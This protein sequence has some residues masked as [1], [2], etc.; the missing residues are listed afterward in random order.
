MNFMILLS[1]EVL[2]V[3][4]FKI[5]CLSSLTAFI[6]LYL[7]FLF[8]LPYCIDLNQYS[9]QITRSIQDKT[10]YQIVLRDLK[11]KT[12]WNLSIGAL[13]DKVDLKYSN[14]EKFAQINNL[15]AKFSLLPFLFKKVHIDKIS[16]DKFLANIEDAKIPRCINTKK[17]YVPIHNINIKKYRI[18]YL[19]N[20]ND[21]TIK[22]SDLEISNFVP[23]K[24]IKINTK[25]G[26]ILNKRKQIVYDLA[27]NSEI[28]PKNEDN[29]FDFV[30]IFDDLYNYDVNAEIKTDLHIRKDSID[31]KVDIDKLSFV[32]GNHIYPQSSLKLD[33][34]DGKAKINGSF[35]ADE[36]SKANVTG[37]F[38]TGKKKAVDLNVKIGG[39]N[40]Q[41]I[42]LI[43]KTMSKP[44]GLTKLQSIDARGLIKADF[45]VKSDF[46]NVES[47]GY[48]KIQNASITDKLYN[49]SLNS[50]NSDIDFS[51]DCIQIVK[52]GARLNGEPINIKGIID[53]NANANINVWANNLQLKGVLL[54]LGQAKVLN[55]NE[56]LNG[57]VNIKA[58]LNGR[59]D[60]AF[61]KVESTVNKINLKNKKSKSNIKISKILVNA[62]C[63]KGTKNSALISDLK[64]YPDSFNIISVPKINLLFDENIFDIKNT[65]LYFNNI[66]TDLSGR[67]INIKSIPE[68]SSINIVIPNQISV[69]L[70]G[71]AG[72]KALLKGNL[73]LSGSP[74]KPDFGG[75][76]GI[77]SV[78]IPTIST[79]IGSSS[80]KFGKNIVVSCPHLQIADSTMS[81]NAIVKNDFNNGIVAQ[82][83]NFYSPN[84]NL[85]SIISAFKNQSSSTNF[86]FAI[87]N[88]KSNIDSFKI[89]G[90]SASGVTSAV[91]MKNNI[92]YLDNLRGNAYLGKIGGHISYDFKNK[93][94]NIQ[95]QGRGLSANP[96][97]T[98]LTGKDDNINGK[99]DFDSNISMSGRS[100]NELLKNLKG[101][102]NFIISNGQMGVLGKFEHLLYAQNI[103]SN[104]IFR[105]TLNVVAKALTVKNTGV[106]KYMKGQL[107]FSNGWAN[108]LWIKTSGPSMSLYI[109]GRYYLLDNTVSLIILGKISDDVVRILGPIGEFSMNKAISSIPKIGQIT[110]NFANDFTTSPSYEN[111]S[112]I[113]ELT[114]V[115]EFP[116]KGFKVIIDGD[117]RKQSS[118]KS[119]KW[120]SRPKVTQSFQQE[121][122]SIIPKQQEVPAFVKNLPDL[123]Q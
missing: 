102:T 95:L 36:V 70:K 49:I 104:S 39:M 88:G 120:L 40:I 108:I 78:Y 28:F 107:T 119:F 54:A 56:V 24:K 98:G 117:V 17:N 77:Q 112:Q 62:N 66:K 72:S 31:G 100:K 121:T 33:F 32:F 83:I 13:I 53:K 116:T 109:K 19:K 91:S 30:K 74:Y 44:F 35:H 8:I 87:L 115:T 22:G 10:G 71:Y 85:S 68:L 64:I 21:Y 111:I 81:I 65:N 60:R 61:P 47:N 1:N 55:E 48:L 3:K 105:T 101:N 122:P 5:V 15:E 106:Y 29:K 113:P 82:N 52:A 14:G 45:N 73:V 26:L 90:I 99:L 118:V 2:R 67:I 34:K 37:F 57:I 110:E 27:I 86:K 41:D 93:K 43:A 84:L 11:I 75:S 97:I 7:A 23:G 89:A 103:I 9:P 18:S 51:Q 69:P 4:G 96:A 79:S 114:P 16:A 76:I 94:T 80:I 123:K 38:K 12:S 50:V 58:S 20:H 92:L 25:G 42:I 59:L 6:V 63:N 46:K